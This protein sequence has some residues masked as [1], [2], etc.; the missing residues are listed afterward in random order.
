MSPFNVYRSILPGLSN[1]RGATNPQEDPAHPSDQAIATR[2]YEMFQARG[3]EHGFD[4]DDWM[5]ARRDLVAEALLTIRSHDG[6][7]DA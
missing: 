5:E 4:R 6:P 2:A 7:P 1:G 3:G